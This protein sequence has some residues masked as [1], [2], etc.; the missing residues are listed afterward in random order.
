MQ[1]SSKCTHLKEEEKKNIEMDE[2]Q[3]WE[4]SEF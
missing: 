3:G 4:V 2:G 1:L